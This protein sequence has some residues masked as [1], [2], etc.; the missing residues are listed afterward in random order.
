MTTSHFSLTNTFL[1]TTNLHRKTPPCPTISG[2]RV[3][4]TTNNL[5]THQTVSTKHDVLTSKD[6][7]ESDKKVIVGTYARTPVVFS[8]GKGC[9]LFDVEGQ[10]YLDLTSGIA[11]NA[12]GHCDPD[13][14]QAVTQQAN[15]LTHV[16]NIF[17]TLPQVELAKRLVSCSFADRVFFTNSGTEANEAAIKFARKFQRFSHPDKKHPPTEFIS[18][19]NSF[20]GRTMGALA[21]TSKEHYRTPFQ[22]VM[23]GVTFLEYGDTQA[24]TE[25]IQSGNIAAVF[26]EP[27][28]GEGGIYSATKDFLQSLRAAC[29]VAGSL[30]VFDE[31]QCGLGRTGYL[32]AHEDYNVFPDIMTLAKPL[33]GGLPIGAV[34]VTEKV[35]EAINYGDH[36]STFAGGPLVCNA[37]IVVLDKISNPSF[38]ASVSSK[39]QYFMKLLSQKLGGNSHVKEVR[40]LG[41]IIG[42]ELDVPAAPLVDACLHSGLLI[43]TAGKGNV[44][45][46]VPPLIISEKELEHA[47]EVLLKCLPA[48]D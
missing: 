9:K 37:A 18:F 39:G 2:R 21:L 35:A 46:L 14:I 5:E 31:V 19:S 32:W 36:G 7:M 17:Y 20:H 48:L 33:A 41:L 44:V 38:L 10:E 6:V 1:P 22:P 40:G 13:W 30:L 45:R 12:L 34:L 26:V 29:D 24:A 23:P 8:S 25:L 15:T 28:Q 16:S 42:I 43:L 27:I 4:F 3:C 11:V 47:A